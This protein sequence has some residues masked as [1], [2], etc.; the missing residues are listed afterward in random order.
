MKDLLKCALEGNV[1]E[2]ENY[3][4]LP[5]ELLAKAYIISYQRSIKLKHTDDTIEKELSLI[6]KQRE[7]ALLHVTQNINETLI[8]QG[9][10]NAI[11]AD[12]LYEKLQYKMTENDHAN[13]LALF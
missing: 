12:I 9:L 1:E 11:C 8:D 3:L 5:F 10:K 6:K 4:Q 13:I 7:K 2:I